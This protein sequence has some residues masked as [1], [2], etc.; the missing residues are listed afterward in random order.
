VFYFLRKVV[1]GANEFFDYTAVA[2]SEAETT[3]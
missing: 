3:P 2:D 1:D